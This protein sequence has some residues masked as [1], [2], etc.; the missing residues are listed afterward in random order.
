MSKG[1][2][3]NSTP[4]IKPIGSSNYAPARKPQKFV[5]DATSAL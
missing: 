3:N 1:T 4:G 5:M 2:P